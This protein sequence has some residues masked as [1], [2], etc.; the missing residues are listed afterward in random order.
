MHRNKYPLV[1][2]LPPPSYLSLINR[3]ITLKQVARTPENICNWFKRTM[4]LLLSRR[5]GGFGPFQCF[6]DPLGSTDLLNTMVLSYGDLK[7]VQY[8]R[9]TTREVGF[10][11]RLGTRFWFRFFLNVR[12]LI[13]LSPL[14]QT[15]VH[16]LL[17]IIYALYNTIY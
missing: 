3:K 2:V 15:I 14:P 11:S 9:R 7:G 16:K 10:G 4:A 5:M 13:H 17:S 6:C 8:I 1:C 12:K